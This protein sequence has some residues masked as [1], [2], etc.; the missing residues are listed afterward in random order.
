MQIGM[1]HIAAETVEW[2]KAAC[3]GGELSRTA[4]AD[5]FCRM[6]GWSGAGLRGCGASAR[7]LLPRLAGELGVRLPEAAAMDLDPHA[8]PAPDF[9]DVSVECSLREFG[10]VS[11]DLVRGGEERRRWEAM[12][13]TWHPLRRLGAE[14]AAPS[15]RGAG[16]A[17]FRRRRR[18]IS[19]HTPPAGRS[20]RSRSERHG[21]VGGTASPRPGSSFGRVTRSSAGRP[22]PGSNIGRRIDDTNKRIDDMNDTLDKRIEGMGNSLGARIDGIDGRL[23]AIEN[24][25]AEIKGKLDFV[26]TYLLGRNDTRTVPAGE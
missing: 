22:T 24:G 26:E 11:L 15:G 6:E 9:A 16:R 12:I 2:F 5:E 7:K 10:A 13:E 3:K 8:R 25:Q 14:A 18:W 20:V 19:I 17:P 4:L 21:I 1:R 23:R